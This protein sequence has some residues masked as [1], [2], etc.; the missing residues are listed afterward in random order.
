[1][2]ACGGG[3]EKEPRMVLISRPQPS[4]VFKEVVLEPEQALFRSA[5]TTSRFFL[6][7]GQSSAVS[8]TQDCLARI[9]L[10]ALR[11]SDQ[12][13]VR[14]RLL[15]FKVRILKPCYYGSCPAKA[16]VA[17]LCLLASPEGPVAQRARSATKDR[18]LR[19]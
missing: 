16:S 11:R 7:R 12:G 5:P 4:V 2:R 6:R 9:R 10:F 18:G 19:R 1:M 15:F 3:R 8:S 14:R 13:P 17:F